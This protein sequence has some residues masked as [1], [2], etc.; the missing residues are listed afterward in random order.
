MTVATESG[1]NPVHSLHR[2]RVRRRNTLLLGASSA[3]HLLILWADD[4]LGAWR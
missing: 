1:L 2:G 4:H 3:L